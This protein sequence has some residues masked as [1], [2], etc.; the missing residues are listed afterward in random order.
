[1]NQKELYKLLEFPNEVVEKLMAYEKS[2]KNEI[3]E[4]IKNKILYRDTWAEGIEELQ[5]VLN[6]DTE[7]LQILWELLDI[8]RAYSYNEYLKREIPQDI[9]V[10]TMKFCTR[11]LYE[12]YRTFGTYHFVWA[13]W[14]PRQISLNEFRIG[15]LEFEYIDGDDRAIGVHIP[16]DADLSMESVKKSF[17]DFAVFSNKYYP[18]WENVRFTCGSWMMM[19]ELNELLDTNSNLVRFQNLFEIDFVDY[20]STSFLKWV[21]P[22]YDII[23]DTLPENT[24]LQR[25]LKKHILEGKPFGVA[26]GHINR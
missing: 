12:H 14:F 15:A 17:D 8:V 9:F 25:V 16:S 4:I 22:G 11:F 21:Y 7:G 23:D 18:G 3:P 1:M 24:T 2:K 13:R 19:P 26:K 5:E 20:E 10:E 6:E